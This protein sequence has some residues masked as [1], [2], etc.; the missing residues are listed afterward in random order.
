[1]KLNKL[2]RN[3]KIWIFFRILFS[4]MILISVSNEFST[5]TLSKNI[6]TISA[7]KI[8]ESSQA[9]V[10]DFFRLI[11]SSKS[12]KKSADAEYSLN[13]YGKFS[14]LILKEFKLKVNNDF[15]GLIKLNYFITTQRA[16]ST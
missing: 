4:V 2:I 14:K 5:S 9:N 13:Y 8:K 3:C 10:Y 1:M 7:I 6:Q 12:F 16:T 15:S 11:P